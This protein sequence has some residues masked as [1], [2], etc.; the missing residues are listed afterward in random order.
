MDEQH[1]KT[2]L[3]KERAFLFLSIA[4]VI[5]LLA[6]FP[7]NLKVF[8]LGTAGTITGGATT[9]QSIELKDYF[10]G[11]VIFAAL[12]VFLAYLVHA[13]RTPRPQNWY[14]QMADEEEFS[15]GVDQ[16]MPLENNLERINRE[17]KNLRRAKEAAADI[18]AKRAKKLTKVPDVEEIHLEHTLRNINAKLQGYA[19]TPLVLEAPR[20]KSEWDDSLEQ[21]KQELAGVDK[22]KFKKAKV[23]EDA[24]SRSDIALRH[25]SKRFQEELRTSLSNTKK[26]AKPIMVLEEPARKKQWN[27]YLENVNQALGKVDEMP[28]KK[29]KILKKIPLITKTDGTLEQRLLTRELQKLHKTLEEEKQNIPNYSI[30]RYIPSS[31]EWEL[32]KIKRHIQK[33]GAVKNKEE[34]A[35]IEEKLAKIYR[36]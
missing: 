2:L 24:P 4:I 15:A 11:L 9:V 19:K 33:K 6:G 17:L 14:P 36:E 34:L 35:E 12:M 22:M 28:I 20:E 13:L 31:R 16:N 23:R 21:V 27:T 25:E 30:K 3:S 10:I 1:S 7:E 29:V 18:P 26:D 8:V 32:A 5:T